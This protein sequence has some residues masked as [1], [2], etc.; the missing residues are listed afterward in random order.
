MNEVL[1][2]TIWCL[3]LRG[4]F[5]GTGL[6]INWGQWFSLRENSDPGHSRGG[7]SGSGGK[8]NIVDNLSVLFLIRDDAD[9]QLGEQVDRRTPVFLS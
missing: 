9:G 2:C 4:R 7:R 1:E 6:H 5:L 8:A 3:N